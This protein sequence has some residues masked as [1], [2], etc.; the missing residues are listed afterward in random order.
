MRKTSSSVDEQ[1]V[2]IQ[3]LQSRI[4]ELEDYILE[5]T[6]MSKIYSFVLHNFFSSGEPAPPS[7]LD[8]SLKSTR[9]PRGKI[10]IATIKV[11]LSSL[12]LF[13]F[14]SFFLFIFFVQRQVSASS[15]LQTFV[16]HGKIVDEASAASSHPIVKEGGKTARD[17]KMEVL[18]AQEEI[19]ATRLSVL[20]S[21][22]ITP[23]AELEH[24]NEKVLKGSSFQELRK[25]LIAMERLSKELS[26][27]LN[28]KLLHWTKCGEC[29]GELMWKFADSL[30]SQCKY[31]FNSEHEWYIVNAWK[32]NHPHAALLD[33]L[34]TAA[35]SQSGHR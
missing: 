24:N 15:N 16:N 9:T 27:K 35:E 20:L 2:L 18:A 5:K 1:N 4:L 34:L 29:V 32:T 10:K 19:N 17:R 13:F 33:S 11:S 14:F 8:L 6:G 26:H 21:R 22:F 23:L 12:L 28:E 31:E 3:N 25:Y 7:S 30:K